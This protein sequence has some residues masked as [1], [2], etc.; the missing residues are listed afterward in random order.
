MGSGYMAAEIPSMCR[1]LAI[2]LPITLPMAISELPLTLETRLTSSSGV[3]VPKDTMV[4]P[5]TRSDNPNFFPKEIEPRTKKSAPL[6][7]I[8]KPSKN[9]M[10]CNTRVVYEP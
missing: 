5:I 2:L 6:I 9:R 3:E 4:N 8:T 1:M 7:R 10:N